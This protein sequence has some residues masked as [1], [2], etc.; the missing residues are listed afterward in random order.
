MA[1]AFVSH[2]SACEALRSH[3]LSGTPWPQEQRFLPRKGDCIRLQRD[4]KRLDQQVGLSRLGI[5]STPVDLLIPSSLMRT[6]GKRARTHGWEPPLPPESMRRVAQNVLV[7]SPEFVILQLSHRHIRH[8]PLVDAMADQQMDEQATLD[9]FGI[10][11]EAPFE[12]LVEWE[13]IRHLVHVAQTAMEFAGTYRLPVLG[14][15]ATYQQPQLMTVE[16]ALA[17]LDCANER[18]DTPRARRALAL[19]ANGSASP[20]ETSLYLMLTLPVEMGGFGLPRPEL[21]VPVDVRLGDENLSPDLLWRDARLV[22]EYNSSEFHAGQG[23]D[24]TDHDIMRANALVAA[25][26]S[27]LEATPGIVGQLSRTTVLAQQ[28]ASLLGIA[29]RTP[30]DEQRRFREKLHRELFS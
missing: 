29:L 25:G 10:D 19:A 11:A 26:F 27:V 15:K 23:A 5:I 21:N 12:D 7:S 20:V 17:F 16:S 13:R 22:V 8:Y 6:R 3:G 4:L 2:E 28:V 18:N 24:K 9:G 1:F 14:E 30:S